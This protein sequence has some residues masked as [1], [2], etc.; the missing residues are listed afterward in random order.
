M[1]KP[2]SPAKFQAL[3]RRWYKKANK[4]AQE[5][6]ETGDIEYGRD[7]NK[8]AGQTFRQ[9]GDGSVMLWDFSAPDQDDSVRDWALVDSSGHEIEQGELELSNTAKYEYYDRI[10]TYAAHTSPR[11]RKFL[12]L[13]IQKGRSIAA[14]EMSM[15]QSEANTI[16]SATLQKLGLPKRT[17]QAPRDFEQDTPAPVRVLSKSEIAKLGYKAPKQIKDKP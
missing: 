13:S 12:L 16:W 2:L 3:Q 8:T 6:G 9:S 15:S 11:R 14:K 17:V 5:R 7:L 4:L 10:M 1:P